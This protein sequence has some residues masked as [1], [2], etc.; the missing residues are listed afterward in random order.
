MQTS[1][2]RELRGAQSPPPGGF[3]VPA[4]AAMLGGTD[5]KVFLVTPPPPGG[6]R[7]WSPADVSTPVRSLAVPGERPIRGGGHVE[8]IGWGRFLAW[9]ALAFGLA[10][11]ASVLI[12][13]IAPESS[14]MLWFA[15]FASTAIWAGLMAE[16]R[17]RSARGRGSPIAK[18]GMALGAAAL[19]TT[20]YAFVVVVSASAGTMLP[21][22][23]HWIDAPTGV[24]QITPTATLPNSPE[25]A[26][27]VEQ[28]IEAERLTL[29]QSVGSA[30]SMLVQT[31]S[32]D[33]TWPAT[34]SVTTDGAELRSP[35]GAL[36]ALLPP[37]TQVVYSTSSDRRQFS[38]ILAG[39]LGAMARYE[40]TTAIVDTSTPG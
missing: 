32:P 24:R 11:M 16:P 29:A 39:P 23:A 35:D 20:I 21:A 26:P 33:G 19:A 8:G 31:A 9:T 22:P 3:P 27:A 25:N 37:G 5:P 17:Y 36:L 30:A 18:A 28:P 38:L 4:V 34:L 14:R 10:S 7:D 12:V 6:P 13:P 15:F 2:G 1:L 40:S